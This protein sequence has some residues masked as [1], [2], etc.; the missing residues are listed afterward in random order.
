MLLFVDRVLKKIVRQYRKAV[1]RK[2]IKCPHKNFILVDTVYV[3]NTNIRL[4][5][6]VSIYPNVMFFGDGPIEIGDNVSIGNNTLIY[7]SKGGGIT[8]GNDTMIGAQSYITD[9]DHGTKLGKKMTD[10]QNSVASVHIGSDVWIAANVT[11]LKGSVINN[12]AIV[13]AKSLL[14][15]TVPENGVAVGIPAKVIKFRE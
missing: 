4:G 14:K 15:G 2:K 12:G 13:G 3:I 6:N 9:T 8:I 11:V 10:Q 1:F 5:K 7:S